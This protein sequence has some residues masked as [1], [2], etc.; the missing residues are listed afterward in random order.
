MTSHGEKR[1]EV[2]ALEAEIKITSEMIYAA[3][4]V[5]WRWPLMEIG[6]AEAE[7]FAEEML[8]RS[9]LI[10]QKKID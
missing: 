4:E 9:L 7:M 10:S 2:G 6:E 8:R 3:A 1:G 5:L